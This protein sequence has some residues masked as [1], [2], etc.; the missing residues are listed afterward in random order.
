MGEDEI[1]LWLKGIFSFQYLYNNAGLV[2]FLE[3][4]V[5]GWATNI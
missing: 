3:W 4:L 1:T 5:A 2:K